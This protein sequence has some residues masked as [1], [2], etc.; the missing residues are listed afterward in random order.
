VRVVAKATKA[1]YSGRPLP[2][3][4]I[5]KKLLSNTSLEGLI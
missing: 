4:G 2:A 3:E 5:I 1:L